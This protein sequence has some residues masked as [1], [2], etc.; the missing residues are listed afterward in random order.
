MTAHIEVKEAA[1]SKYLPEDWGYYYVDLRSCPMGWRMPIRPLE[2]IFASGYG[3][4]LL[5][6]W[7]GFIASLG[8]SP[9][10]VQTFTDGFQAGFQTQKEA[11]EL[12]TKLR[13]NHPF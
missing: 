9:S 13:Q 3:D 7:K 10:W 8:C 11:E 2:K 1:R 12:A 5:N 4:Q 6:H